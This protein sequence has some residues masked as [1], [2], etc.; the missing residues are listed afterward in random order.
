MKIC[1]SDNH[2]TLMPLTPPEAPLIFFETFL[3]FKKRFKNVLFATNVLYFVLPSSPNF[4]W[5]HMAKPYV[6][7]DFDDVRCFACNKRQHSTILLYR[8]GLHEG[9]LE[10]AACNSGNSPVINSVIWKWESQVNQPR[11]QDKNR[12]YTKREFQ[13]QITGQ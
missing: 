4:L 5:F 6:K 13:L 3:L 8:V 10:G 1:S 7:H 11:K 9:I 2:H 12:G